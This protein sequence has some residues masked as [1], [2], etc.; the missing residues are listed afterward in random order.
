MHR[1]NKGA[2][3]TFIYTTVR[4]ISRSL[5]IKCHSRCINSSIKESLSKWWTRTKLC[6]NKYNHNTINKCFSSTRIVSRLSIMLLGQRTISITWNN[7][8]NSNITLRI[9]FKELT[10]FHKST[11]NNFSRRNSTSSSRKATPSCLIWPRTRSTRCSKCIRIRLG[12]RY[13]NSE[14]NS[15]MVKLTKIS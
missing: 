10:R 8:S 6:N 3:H 2:N 5:R 4:E 13:L 11:T 9:Q 1:A 15:M 14:C 7:I 12:L